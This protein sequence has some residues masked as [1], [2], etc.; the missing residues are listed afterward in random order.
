MIMY[1]LNSEIGT[2]RDVNYG[3]LRINH[4]EEAVAC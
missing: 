4:A 2:D 1:S 3:D